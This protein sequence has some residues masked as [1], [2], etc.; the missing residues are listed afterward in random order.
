MAH[1]VT[2]PSRLPLPAS[3]LPSLPSPKTSPRPPITSRAAGSPSGSEGGQAG[4]EFDHLSLPERE[5]VLRYETGRKTRKQ[6]PPRGELTSG[7]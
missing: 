4:P 3:R 6:A 7:R 2:P 5:F 1:A